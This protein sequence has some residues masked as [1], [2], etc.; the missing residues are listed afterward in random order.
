MF[1]ALCAHHQGVKI[2]FYSIW[3]HHTC[4]WPSDAPV[5]SLLYA[6]KCFEH[7]VLIIRGS[8]LYYTASGVITPVGVRPVHRTASYRF[9]DTRC[10]IKQFWPPDDEHI[11]LETFRGIK[12]TYYKTRICALGL[13][14]TKIILK[15]RSAKHKKLKLMSDKQIVPMTGTLCRSFVSNSAWS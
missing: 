11:V 4:R 14:V 3:F 12:E 1:R 13:S 6:S 15:C 2:V 7:Y 10:C 9:D 8:K 5:I